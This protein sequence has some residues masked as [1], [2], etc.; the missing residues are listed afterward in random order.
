[1][2]KA[3]RTACAILLLFTTAATA[4]VP[5]VNWER[6]KVEILRHYRSLVQIDTSNPP[7]NETKAVEYLKKVFDAEGIPAKTFALEPSR[8][9]LVA[10]IKGNGSKRPILL[11]AHTDVVGVQREKWPVDPFG[12]V[13][14]DGYIWGR[15]S[16]DDKDKLAANL[17]VML[18][19][20]RSG[21]VLDRD[22]IFLAESGEEA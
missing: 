15:G 4:Q 18:L 1:M 19:A 12:A 9:N 5:A 10:R 13:L 20:K 7:G 6:Q 2:M 14:K 8:A 22:L 16:R 21:V 11:M 17:M 3:A